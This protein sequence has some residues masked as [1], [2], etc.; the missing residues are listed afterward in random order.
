[1]DNPL[2][3]LRTS[4]GRLHGLCRSLDDGQLDAPSYCSD[5]TIAGVLSH[6]GSGA[7][8][9]QSNLSD[10]LA[11]RTAREDFAPSVWDEWNAKSS[12]SKADDALVADQGLLEA[13]H[14]VSAP[15]RTRVTFP[16]GPLVAS[17]DQA[18]GFRLN[19]HALHTWDIEVV[20]DDG[21]RLPPDAVAVVVDNLEL[22]ARFAARPTGEERTV[23]LRTTGPDRNFAL[24]VGV[25]DGE[26][27][28]SGDG[29]PEPE[30][31]LPAEALCRLVYG[32]LDPA[33]TPTVRDGAG[34]L[35]TLRA[36]FPG[37]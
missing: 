12:R 31:V 2:P 35:D 1:M 26:L 5:W 37:L 25:G 30:L 28:P 13:L 22:I 36:V 9:M 21:A 8:I 29:G 32:R 16:F 18:V 19:E 27:T 14:A 17:F 23:H 20:L 4:V 6:L 24:H 34:L 33:H 11:G 3:A 10:A 7:V 15:D